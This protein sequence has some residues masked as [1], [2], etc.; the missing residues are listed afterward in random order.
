MRLLLDTQAWLWWLM[1]SSRLPQTARDAI[2][3]P[4]NQPLISAISVVEL[5]EKARSGILPGMQPLIDD[6]EGG[7]DRDRFGR[8]PIT[9]EHAV[10]AAAL[11]G[12]PD[13]LLDRILIAQAQLEDITL[14][15]NDGRFDGLG[16]RRLWDR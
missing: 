13:D 2:A 6:I 12:A 15:S 8:L 14:I 5:L 11:D 10:R 4:A 9:T 7:I 1:E 3:D 16:V